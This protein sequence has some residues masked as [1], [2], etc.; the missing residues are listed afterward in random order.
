[1]V[2]RKRPNPTL[3]RDVAKDLTNYVVLDYCQ[4]N[5]PGYRKR[6]RIAH[7]GNIQWNPR[8]LCDPTTCGQCVEGKHRLSAQRGPCKGKDQRIDRCSL[9]ALHALPGEL[10]EEILAVCQGHMWQLI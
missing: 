7:S 9:D 6:T 10:T 2:H 1:M 3:G 5:G 4:Y 8:P